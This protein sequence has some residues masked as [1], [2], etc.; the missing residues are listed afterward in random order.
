M[1]LQNALKVLFPGQCAACGTLVEDAHALC[2]ACWVDTAFIDGLS[3][4]AC[5]LPM[6]GEA[7]GARP[8][9]DACLNTPPLWHQGRAVFMYTGQGRRMVLALK[10]GDRVEIAKPAARWM[11]ARLSVLLPTGGA[12]VP[13]PL[14]WTRLVARRFNQAALLANGI[15]SITGHDVIVDALVRRRRTGSQEN[16]SRDE[17]FGNLSGAMVAHPSRAKQIVGRRIVVVD[18][19]LTSG[20]TL[21]EATRA[22]LDAGAASVSVL[23]LA[24]VAKAPW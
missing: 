15:G 16:R 21:T 11:A 20:A 9:C 22:L 24:R 18:D 1:Q 12:L 14:H 23:V 13:V 10:H 6:I 4:D 17:R 2:G 3:C 7:A 19:V 5:G 8:L